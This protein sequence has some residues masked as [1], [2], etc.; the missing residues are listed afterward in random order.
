VEIA[1]GQLVIG[2]A[3]LLIALAEI[4]VQTMAISGIKNV[5]L[6]LDERL[7]DTERARSDD[8]TNVL[9]LKIIGG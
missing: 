9:L 5:R 4:G 6:Q 8:R 2:F 7:K 1:Q 3:H